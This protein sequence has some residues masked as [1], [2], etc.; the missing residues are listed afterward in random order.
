MKAT[1]STE[2][3]PESLPDLDNDNP[4]YSDKA[5]EHWKNRTQQLTKDDESKRLNDDREE[6]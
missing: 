3:K 2:T 5:T 1:K 4:F 6:E